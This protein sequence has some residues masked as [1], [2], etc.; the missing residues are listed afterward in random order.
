MKFSLFYLISTSYFP[1]LPML[2]TAAI[3]MPVKALLLSLVKDLALK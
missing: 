2:I 3:R 1:A